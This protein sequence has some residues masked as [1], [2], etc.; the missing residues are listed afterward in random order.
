MEAK[1]RAVQGANIP[2]S[3]YSIYV[4]T[5]STKLRYVS[6]FSNKNGYDS[7]VSTFSTIKKFETFFKTF[8]QKGSLYQEEVLSTSRKNHPRG[9]PPLKVSLSS[10]NL[11]GDVVDIFGKKTRK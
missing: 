8:F 3:E 7:T 6:T 5:F 10:N 11:F 1:Y 2:D 9:K 4:S